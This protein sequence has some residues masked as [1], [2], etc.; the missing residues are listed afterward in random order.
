[1]KKII[2]LLAVILFSVVN[3]SVCSADWFNNNSSIYTKETNLYSKS[4]SLVVNQSDSILTLYAQLKSS[5]RNAVMG[6]LSA[7]NRRV[8]LLTPGVY[9]I[10]ESLILDTDFVDIASISGNPKD[11]II[12]KTVFEGAPPRGCIIQTANNVC[13][14]G[15]TI[16][17]NGGLTIDF[18]LDINIT[19]GDNTDSY[20]RNMDFEST[21]D[22]AQAFCVTGTSNIDGTWENCNA[23]SYAWRLAS[24]KVLKATMKDCNS[25]IYS[26]GGDASGISISGTFYRCVTGSYSFGGCTSV[27]C[28]ITSDALFVDCIAGK[29]SYAMGRNFAGTAIRCR[30]GA[31][32][33]GGSSSDNINYAGSFSGVAEYCTAEDIDGG[34][35]GMGFA[36]N[37]FSGQASYCRTNTVG[38]YASGFLSSR[39]GTITDNSEFASYTT[40]FDGVNNDL[41]ITSAKVGTGGNTINMVFIAVGTVGDVIVDNARILLRVSATTTATEAIGYLE[42]DADAMKLITVANAADNDGSGIVSALNAFLSGGVDKPFAYNNYAYAPQNCVVDTAVAFFDNGQTYTNAGDDDAI[43]F[44]LPKAIAGLEYTFIDV[45]VTAGADVTI[46]ADGSEEIGA[47][48]ISAVGNTDDSYGIIHIKCIV[49]GAWIIVDS[50]GTW[51]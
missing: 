8:L 48:G 45:S 10:T 7:T 47:L 2:V 19:S 28:N 6:V 26:Y 29:C 18:G 24:S 13:L 30:G 27:G 11:T 46:T 4:N 32:C 36:S 49:D 35:F 51:S 15:F 9:T 12:Q 33:F 31:M 40:S 50:T 17:T 39:L 16:R 14:T 44:T 43:T 1:M 25:G 42:A 20:Y 34:S 3:I 41:V 22:P 21:K 23:D 37:V 38:Q 5:D